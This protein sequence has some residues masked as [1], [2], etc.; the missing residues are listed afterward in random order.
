M[1]VGFGPHDETG[2]HVKELYV[3]KISMRKHY[4]TQVIIRATIFNV[5]YPGISLS[6]CMYVS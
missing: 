6:E 5:Q 4:I 2:W 1:R 3:P